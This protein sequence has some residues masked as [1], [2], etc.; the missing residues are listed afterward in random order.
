MQDS[1]P[2]LD[3]SVDI[4]END[5]DK[6]KR[7]VEVQAE[8][9]EDWKEDNSK[10]NPLLTDDTVFCIDTGV[11]KTVEKKFIKELPDKYKEKDMTKVFCVSLEIF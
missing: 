5:Y 2:I 4:D 1:I 8:V 9:L 7:M 11:T 3:Q 6:I 10:D